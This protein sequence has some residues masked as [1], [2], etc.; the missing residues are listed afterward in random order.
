MSGCMNVLFSSCDSAFNKEWEFRLLMFYLK[1]KHLQRLIRSIVFLR[2]WVMQIM[3][4]YD[5]VY[6]M[7][8]MLVQISAKSRIIYSSHQ[9]L[10]T[11]TLCFQFQRVSMHSAHLTHAEETL[12]T[13]SCH[14]SCNRHGSTIKHNSTQETLWSSWLSHIWPTLHNISSHEQLSRL[15]G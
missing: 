9:T 8:L 14:M 5:I 4:E 12:C 10:S 13:K 15:H 11:L 7:I 6:Q 2:R 1:R 3:N